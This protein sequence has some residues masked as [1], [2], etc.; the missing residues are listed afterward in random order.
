[1]THAPGN[2][3][4]S[5]LNGLQEDTRH[6]RRPPGEGE[7]ER[8]GDNLFRVD[9]LNEQIWIAEEVDIVRLRNKQGMLRVLLLEEVNAVHCSAV[10]LVG[11]PSDNYTPP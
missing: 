3:E 9:G 2:T 11:K 8:C 7:E 5:K 10:P 6:R 4:G 1:M